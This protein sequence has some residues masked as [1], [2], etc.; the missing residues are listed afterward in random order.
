MVQ[1]K[2]TRMPRLWTSTWDYDVFWGACCCQDH[3]YL[4][5]LH[6]YMKPW[7]HLYSDCCHGPRLHQC[8]ETPRVWV[9]VLISCCYLGLMG[10]L[11]SGQSPQIVSVS[12]I[13]TTTGTTYSGGLC[14][15]QDHGDVRIH[16]AL[17]G[18]SRSI[19]V[20]QRGVSDNAHGLQY[21]MMVLGIYC[22]C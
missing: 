1:P 22:C 17:E 3:D 10:C 14:C 8:T 20:L 21:D 15:H 7:C 16:D 11:G 5:G 9:D 2:A 19:C 12:E 18:M 6:C 4:G 13:L